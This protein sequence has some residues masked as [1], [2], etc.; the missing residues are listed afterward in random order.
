MIPLFL[1]L[2]PLLQDH[3]PQTRISFPQI[4]VQ[5]DPAS[6]TVDT[7]T[8]PPTV[9]LIAPP[10]AVNFSDGETPQGIVNGTNAAFTLAFAPS[11]AT[12]LHLYRNGVRQALGIDYTLSGMAIT[13]TALSIP[14]SSGI[15]DILLA[16]YR[17]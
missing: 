7:T 12:S 6:F 4:F 1:A 16:D 17:H 10:S 5:Y 2:I 14:Q 13:F 3:A 11:P 8:K 15:P 9:R